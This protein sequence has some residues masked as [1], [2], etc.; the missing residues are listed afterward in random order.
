[1]R[2]EA[3]ALSTNDTRE[4][5][6]IMNI[7]AFGLVTTICALGAASA[8][9]P[10]DQLPTA[11][12]FAGDASQRVSLNASD[13]TLRAYA[14]RFE[15]VFSTRTVEFQ[16]ALGVKTDRLQSLRFETESIR[17][18]N[19]ETLAVS[20]GQQVVGNQQ[21]RYQRTWFDE[22]YDVH[23]DGIEQSFEFRSL[24]TG[25]G[26]LVVRMNLSTE[27]VAN[28]TEWTEAGLAFHLDGVPGQV[29]IGAVTGID[30]EG[31]RCTGSLRCKGG[32][33]ELALP[34]SFVDSAAL[35][36]V[37][38][39]WIGNGFQGSASDFDDARPDVAYDESSDTY[40]M[41]WS[42]EIGGLTQL[43]GRAVDSDGVEVFGTMS[44]NSS[45]SDKLYPACANVANQDAFVVV[46]TEDGNIRATAVT[47]SGT[48]VIPAGMDV[49]ASPNLDSF[50]DV[51]GEAT[52]LDNDALAV[53]WDFS[54]A[55]IEGAQLELN[56]AASTLVAF[57]HTDLT[58]LAGG[59]GSG[60]SLPTISKSGGSTG[61]HMIAFQRSQTD[62]EVCA[63]VV[64]RNLNALDNFVQI[65]AN[66]VND[67][68]PSCDGDGRNWVVAWERDEAGSISVEDI[69]C[70]AVHLNAAENAAYLGASGIPIETDVNDDEHHASVSWLGESVLIA[71]ADQNSGSDYDV[72]C[73]PIDPFTC[74]R[75][76]FEY[77]V[78]SST[79]DQDWP[80][81]GSA[82]SGGSDSD[83]A[84]IIWEEENQNSIAFIGA[85]FWSAEEGLTTEE[86]SG[87]GTGGF[88]Y[89]TRI[90][91]G[92]T[93]FVHRLRSSRSFSPCALVFSFGRIDAGCGLCTLVPD[94]TTG[95]AFGASTDFRGNASVA[96]SIPANSSLAG[97]TFYDQWLVTAPA[98]FCA[99]VGTDFS[100]AIRVVIQ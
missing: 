84:L 91:T 85:R 35:P 77:I 21:V 5:L 26:D 53:W 99:P 37:L 88:A 87:C 58:A 36:L 68:A 15:T 24:P 14:R 2:G 78:T 80:A 71:Y 34:E 18:T 9:T 65:T 6:I 41:V 93:D 48:T 56:V 12:G 100:N 44:V 25:T 60:D 13:G 97:L 66:S 83:R 20:P 64:D 96:M 43:R 73:V 86:V 50:P 57:D 31:K 47:A 55:K 32:A 8:Q 3:L 38:D 7:R 46:W 10:L 39:P 94:P 52:S 89:A 67:T 63:M 42:R 70:T 54:A 79:L 30:A 61:H 74:Q 69:Y 82:F 29:T 98:P 49:Q 81:I 1:M 19:G 45:F 51:G 59:G 11:N 17:R 72:T 62:L 76:A 90:T 4:Q 40:F 16:P 22:I 75:N 95:F 27:L 23:V 28:T 92:N 33:L